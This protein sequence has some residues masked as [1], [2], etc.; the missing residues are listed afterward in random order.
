[1]S[2]TMLDDR[3]AFFTFK[4]AMRIS[5]LTLLDLL[6]GIFLDCVLSIF[7]ICMIFAHLGDLIAYSELKLAMCTLQLTPRNL[8][9]CLDMIDFA[10]LSL[11]VI[12]LFAFMI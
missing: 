8:T 3:I 11:L 5:Q 2:M 10:A 1:M 9:L 4:S 6:K 12:I 7:T